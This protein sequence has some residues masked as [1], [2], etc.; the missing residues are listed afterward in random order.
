[1]FEIRNHHPS[2]LPVLYRI[3]LETGAHGNDATGLIDAEVLGHVYLGPYC[4]L[5]P[6]CAFT[7]THENKPVGYIVGTD[8]TAS[9]EARCD[10]EWWPNLRER[11][12]LAQQATNWDDSVIA[13]MHRREPVA[14]Y[15][16]GYPGHLHI[17]CLPVAQGK[18]QGKALMDHFL[19]ALAAAHVRGVH[20]GVSKKNE[21]AVRF[22]QAYGFEKIADESGAHIMGI[23]L[24]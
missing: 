2:D 16:E 17:D 6:E 19:A 14:D 15:C 24:G 8:D 23:R 20:L 10:E 9:F 3:C 13:E 18:G 5:Q 1:M 22:Y 11:Y 21:R 12:P 7:L 4:V